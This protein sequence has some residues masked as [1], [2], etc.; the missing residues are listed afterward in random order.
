ML[1]LAWML[2]PAG[3]GSGLRLCPAALAQTA[4][5]VVQGKV[6]NGSAAPLP[7]A[8]VYLQDQ[9]TNAVKTYIA[10]ADGGYR[11]GQLPADTDYRVWAEYGGQKSKEKL[12]SSFDT[13]LNV[14]VDFKVG[15]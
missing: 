9:K 4:A 12:I 3:A 13:K 1:A 14:T 10:V 11:F 5:K 8:V 15:K 7:G 6:L 2:L